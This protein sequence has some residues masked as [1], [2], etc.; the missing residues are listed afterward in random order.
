MLFKFNSWRNELEEKNNNRSLKNE[1][2]K[3][4]L[5]GRADS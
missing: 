3:N 2:G 4:V 1:H 5:F